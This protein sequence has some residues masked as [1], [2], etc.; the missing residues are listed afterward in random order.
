[1]NFDMA[2]GEEEVERLVVEIEGEESV[3]KR[4]SRK[5]GSELK[6]K[7]PKPKPTYPRISNVEMNDDLYAPTFS[8][9]CTPNT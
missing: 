8:I 1:M 9:S 3:C 7:K 5:R 4:V 6:N 2:H